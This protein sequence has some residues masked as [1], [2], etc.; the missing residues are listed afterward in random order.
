MPVYVAAGDATTRDKRFATIVCTGANDET[1]LRAAHDLLPATGGQIV[2]SEGTYW[3]SAPTLFEY[4]NVTVVGAGA[5]Q[6]MGSAQ[7]GVGT[8]IVVQSNFTGAE[9][10]HF[11]PASNDRPSYGIV[12]RDF[13]VDGNAVVGCMDGIVYRSNRGTIDNVH[14]HRM[15][16][17]GLHVRGYS[18]VERG[19]GASTSWNTYDTQ[20][21]NLKIG[22]CSL[23]GLFLDDN[24]TDVQLSC[25]VLWE[26]RNNLRIRSGSLQA[27]VVHTYT[28]NEHN[29]WFDSAGSRTKITNLKCEGANY[30]GL[31]VDGVTT[32]TSDL[33][34]MAANFSNNS[35]SL[36][37]T[38]DAIHI[39]GPSTHTRTT[40]IGCNFSRKASGDPLQRYGVNLVDTFVQFANVQT[41]TF[42]HGHF[43]TAAINNAGDANCVV[44]NNVGI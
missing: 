23:D 37:N 28:A 41:N 19:G 5:G 34:I 35:R 22:D 18:A 3:V 4:H 33:Q 15:T 25:A 29:V 24:A 20:L 42:G 10:L 39:G 27:N 38:Y 11:R 36:T 43:G 8:R 16:G 14:V 32:G 13:T 12:L 30:H 31:F 44:A 7:N 1:K 9:V 17:H 26:N 6:R 40:I 21:T 2:L